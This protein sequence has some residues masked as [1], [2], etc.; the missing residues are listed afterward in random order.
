MAVPS[1]FLLGTALVLTTFITGG[2]SQCYGHFQNLIATAMRETIQSHSSYPDFGYPR[3]RSCQWRIRAPDGYD[4][5]LEVV[6]LDL[7]HNTTHCF[8]SVSI[9]DGYNPE[10]SALLV[11]VCTMQDREYRSGKFMLVKFSGSDNSSVSGRGFRMTYRA[12][13]E[14]NALQNAAQTFRSSTTSFPN[15][16]KPASRILIIGGLVGAVIFILLLICCFCCRRSVSSADRDHRHA[17]RDAPLSGLALPRGNFYRTVLSI[18]DGRETPSTFDDVS[19]GS[20]RH[21]QATDGNTNMGF[22]PFE[23]APPSY[24][25][26]VASSNNRGVP[27]PGGG[28]TGPEGTSTVALPT[29]SEAIMMSDITP[30][31]E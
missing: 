26:A 25:A 9:Y 3:N 17:Q 12:V 11:T 7:E 4:V 6:D 31:P 16:K 21:A 14:A 13:H 2:R 5:Y 27:R 15:T 29:Y 10:D 8:A 22:S 1:I 19:S 20:F 28:V 30:K 24:E 23:E 18:L